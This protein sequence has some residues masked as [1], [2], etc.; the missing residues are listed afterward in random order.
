MSRY[1]DVMV[2]GC[3][4]GKMAGFDSLERRATVT[5]RLLEYILQGGES[6]IKGKTLLS[7]HFEKNIEMF[8]REL[9][10]E[11]S[12]DVIFREFA[13]AGSKSALICLDGLIKDEILTH[14]MQSLT[15]L[16]KKDS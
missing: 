10:A 13:V 3:G 16:K 7:R 4:P 12:F 11:E 6:V 2:V 8:S 15:E 5:R 9:G 14:V 1:P